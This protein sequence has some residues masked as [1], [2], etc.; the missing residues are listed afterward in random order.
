MPLLNVLQA[1]SAAVVAF[2]SFFVAGG[3]AIRSFGEGRL[4]VV[5][6]LAQQVGALL[7][8]LAMLLVAQLWA[9]NCTVGQGLL[10]YLL[11]P[12]VTV[13]FSVALAYL[14][15]ALSLRHPVL[16]LGG[17]GLGLSLL[18]P[19]YDLGLHPQFYTYNH[20]FGGVLG[21]IYDEQLSV[22]AGLFFF[23][24]LTLLWAAA[25]FFL[26]RWLR[27]ARGGV[28]VV[29]CGVAIAVVYAYAGPLGLNTTPQE[30]RSALGG[31]HQT[32]HFDLY[33]DPSR[34]DSAAVAARAADHEAHYARLTRRLDVEE[35]ADGRI[36]S[37]IYP[38]PDV[39]GRLTGA[40]T[41][42]V[43]PVW[44][45][46]PQVHVLDRRVEES[47]GHELAHVAG[48]SYGL[49][50]LKASWAPGLVEGWAVALDPPTPAPS[51]HDRMAT[52]WASDPGD[53]PTERADAL[54]QRLSP[55]GF[56]TGRGAV[57]YTTMG[58]FVTYLL[59][60]Y[61][62]ERLKE[63]YAWGRF[64]A[65]YGQ[66]V[67]QLAR[68]WVA[69]V[70]DRRMVSASSYG[71][72]SR[73]FARPSLFETECPHFVPPPR[74]HLQ[75]AQRAMHRRDTTQAREHLDAALAAA[76][77]LRA[78][79]VARARLRLADGAAEAA[80]RQLDTLSLRPPSPRLLQLRADAH[81]MTGQPD[82]ARALYRRA[83]AHTPRYEPGQRV[84]RMLRHAVAHR[85]DIV[86]L[87]VSGDSAHVQARRLESEDQTAVMAAWQALRWQDSHQYATAASAWRDLSFPPDGW[88]RAW[89]QTA[90]VQRGAWHAEAAA[91]GG[92][93]ADAR[94]VGTPAARQAHQIGA[95]A[96]ART[97]HE[98]IEWPR[99]E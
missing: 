3:A 46:Q 95:D 58:S 43:A 98:W 35:L 75:A 25:A 66:S 2:V 27:V 45:A 9:P 76:P 8:P 60:T 32:D 4:S 44:L 83:V 57:S 59:E 54:A 15:T 33:Y 22:R 88:S 62:P 5:P 47:L 53:S 99:R 90:R 55:W 70:Q 64:E 78:A 28:G 39:K 68:E 96:C 71:L 97:L 13:V 86:T 24:G 69:Y 63:V 80:R 48:R 51:R 42:S 50:L 74:R 17:L 23:R 38:S 6:V 1:E 94:R 11:F 89:R 40:R 31:H 16:W 65:V 20:V 91:R 14:L 26:G 34:L 37:Y 30:L 73:Q 72:V 19:L 67:R 12:G 87:L 56:W 10:F 18:G 49:P 52:A 61:G 79:H 21:P 92:R 84:R 82:T 77:Q 81:A 85:P 36:Q 7:L 93:S 41:T 29:L